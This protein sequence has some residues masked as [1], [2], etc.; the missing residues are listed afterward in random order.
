MGAAAGADVARAGAGAGGCAASGG[1]ALALLTVRLP[2]PRGYGRILRA[3]DG[4]VRSLSSHGKSRPS[5]QP[6]G[7]ADGL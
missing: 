7:W 3:A 5:G 6:L 4:R 2:E 1:E